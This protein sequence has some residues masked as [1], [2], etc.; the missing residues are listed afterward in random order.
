[1]DCTLIWYFVSLI[2]N[3]ELQA[4]RHV[5]ARARAEVEIG[6]LALHC[7]EVLEFLHGLRVMR[8][9]AWLEVIPEQLDGVEIRTPWREVDDIDAVIVEQA[10][11]V[12]A[13]CGDALSCW[14]HH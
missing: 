13:L 12:P 6:G 4:L 14:Y 9:D 3:D 10:R 11:E 1:M 5:E 2:R 7:D 8:V